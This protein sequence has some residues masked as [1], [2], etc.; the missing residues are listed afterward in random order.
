MAKQEQ[1]PNP[2]PPPDPEVPDATTTPE[3]TVDDVEQDTEATGEP[4]HHSGDEEPGS[5]AD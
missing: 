3:R 2:N 5:G 4:V 1:R